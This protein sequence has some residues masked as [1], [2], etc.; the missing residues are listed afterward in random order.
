MGRWSL[1]SEVP[2]YRDRTCCPRTSFLVLKFECM[3]IANACM[4]VRCIND[5]TRQVSVQTSTDE[6]SAK[7][8]PQQRGGPPPISVSSS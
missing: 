6:I 8:N 4:H 2:L 1:I 5:D 3:D 7:L